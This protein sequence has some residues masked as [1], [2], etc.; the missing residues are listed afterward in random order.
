MPGGSS[1]Y[2]PHLEAGT[3]RPTHS[4]DRKQDAGEAGLGPSVENFILGQA[5][6][7]AWPWVGADSS[8]L[9]FGLPVP[10]LLHPT[11]GDDEFIPLPC[12]RARCRQTRGSQQSGGPVTYRSVL[13]RGFSRDQPGSL[14]LPNT[15]LALLG[16]PT[17]STASLHPP[18]GLANLD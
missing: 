8:F 7:W 4:G 14:G 11:H 9:P 3:P 15:R 5:W 13:D 18:K 12:S 6:A 2:G 1:K 10:S 16:R 17:A